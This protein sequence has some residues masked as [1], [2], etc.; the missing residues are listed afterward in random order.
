M[1]GQIYLKMTKYLNI[2]HSNSVFPKISWDKGQTSSQCYS[3]I[4]YSTNKNGKAYIVEKTSGKKKQSN[5]ARDNKI[6][7]TTKSIGFN[8]SIVFKQFQHQCINT[9]SKIPSVTSS[10]SFK[11]RMQ[12]KYLNF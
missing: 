1:R 6:S 3:A 4:K 5:F 11:G 2:T 9:T 12:K 8:Y 7:D 10:N